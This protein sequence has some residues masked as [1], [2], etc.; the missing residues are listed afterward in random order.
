MTTL[1]AHEI[2][3]S[4]SPRQREESFP[5][6][7]QMRLGGGLADCWPAA[8]T[9]AVAMATTLT[10]LETESDLR[11][12]LEHFQHLVGCGGI[13]DEGKWQAETLAVLQELCRAGWA[14][15]SALPQASDN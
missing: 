4:W 13:I 7:F 2:L 1:E 10:T 11:E 5:G 8:A 14:A 12:A 9:A 15:E 6:D 3:A